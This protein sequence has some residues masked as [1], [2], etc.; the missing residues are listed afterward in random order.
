MKL[1]IFSL[2]IIITLS[3]ASN[4]NAQ[5]ALK[6]RPNIVIILADDL[7][8]GDV[9]FHGSEIK[10]PNIDRLSKEGVILNRFYTASICSPTRAGLMTGRFP[11]RFGLRETVYKPWS[12]MGIDTSEVLLPQM[13]A[14]A[15]Y[16]NR[17]LIGKWHLGHAAKMFLPLQRGFTHFYGHYNDVVD[18][19]THKRTGELDW[20]N[21]DETSY[22]KGYTTDLITGEAV[23]SIKA[24]S[25]ESSPFFLYVAF[26]APH[27]PL[28]AKTA[29]VLK[30]TPQKDAGTF[31]GI[32]KIQKP[33]T[34]FTDR[35][36]YS[37]MVT[38]MDDGIGK[39]LATIKQLKIDDNTL[40]LFFS[41]NGAGMAAS[42]GELRGRKFQEWDGELRAP[43]IIKWPNGFKGKRTINKVM[44]YVDIMPTLKEI[45]GIKTKPKIFFD[46]MSMLPV[47]LKEK[48]QVERNLYLGN[49][50]I[51]NN[52]WKLIV[53][54]KANER[55]NLKKDVLIKIATDVSEKKDV[56]D[57]YPLVY[58]NLLEAVKTF[59][60]I[61]AAKTV[62]DEGERSFKAPKNWE[63]LK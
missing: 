61:K 54:G 18:Y 60:E 27:A 31:I 14:Q 62:K 26:N 3:T 12:D 23:R 45:T 38:S 6:K 58:K 53:A 32:E 37:A 46:G 51:I 56:K 40:V 17:A 4:L 34:D 52:D 10:T 8:W 57:E 7:G 49:G 47:L 1:S 42:G 22:D 30:Y 48:K 33:S 24:Y 36:I 9:G 50:A 2:L 13:L 43:A 55:T 19:F 41:D 15:G 11:D 28:Q 21:D 59:D 25:R 35:E 16:K 63:I 39:I 44:G 29:D 20:H 5:T